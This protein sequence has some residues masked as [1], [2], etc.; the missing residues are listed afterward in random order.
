MNANSK[1][2]PILSIILF[3]TIVTLISSISNMI[4]PNLLIISNY[5]GFRG[6]TTP[7]GILTFSF[8][9]LTG[10]A[11]LIFGF[12]ADKIM[13]KWIVFIGTIIFSIF[14][15]FTIFIPP[16]LNGYFL[17][18]FLTIMTGIGY[19]ALIPCIFS[20]IGDI[21]SQEDRSKGFS[22]FSIS[23]LI[24]MV[25]GTGLATFLGNIDWRISYSIIGI[26]GFISALLFIFFREPSRAGRDYSYMLEKDAVEYTYRINFSDLKV[27]FK[28]K[29]NFWLIINFVDTIPTGIILFLLFAYMEDYHGIS[30]DVTL[31]YLILILLATLIGTIVF[32]FIGDKQFKKGSKK[33][34][35]KLALL[36]NIVPIPFIFIALIIPFRAPD[37][38]PG[39]LIWLILFMIGIFINGAVNGNWYATVV[40]LNLPEHRGTV[41]ATSNFF[42]IIGRAIGPLIGS[43]FADTFGFVYGMLISIFF[44]IL[45]PFFWIGVLKNIVPEM[46]A[47]EKI[48]TERLESLIKK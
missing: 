42:D 32:G 43:I 28:K 35:V 16:D 20:L 11:M 2:I 39:I 17:F 4:S 9:I 41:L 13:R 23:S 37:L 47:T 14:S 30:S 33:A 19:G 38:I 10:I 7:L 5:F 27:I 44:W 36:G 18:F 25:I 8:T 22:F 26:A 3:I 1:N 29:A 46:D 45:I 48:F 24:G 34:R 31:I 40:D 6:N 21:V 12:L 15:F